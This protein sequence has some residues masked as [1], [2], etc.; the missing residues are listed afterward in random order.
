MEE[1]RR[2]D[3]QTAQEEMHVEVNTSL[4]CQTQERPPADIRACQ[5]VA[6]CIVESTRTMTLL[7][8]QQF[9]IIILLIMSDFCP[10][11]WGVSGQEW[12]SVVMVSGFS[13]GVV[14]LRG[15]CWFRALAGLVLFECWSFWWILFGFWVGLV[16]VCGFC[17]VSYAFC[18][19]LVCMC[20]FVGIGWVLGLPSPHPALY[21]PLPTRLPTLSSKG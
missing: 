15:F 16:R 18:V 3:V 13:V 11:A 8:A 5:H 9:M 12:A 6:A 17:M 7:H 14:V 19:S 4:T 10:A 20:F 2:P 1:P 21:A